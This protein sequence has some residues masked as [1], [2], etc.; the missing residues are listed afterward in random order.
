MVVTFKDYGLA[1]AEAMGA[2]VARASRPAPRVA[3][4]WLSTHQLTWFGACADHH[5]VQ[6]SWSFGELRDALL[7]EPGRRATVGTFAL[8]QAI[9]PEVKE[10]QLRG[11]CEGLIPQGTDGATRVF[12]MRVASQLAVADFLLTLP[13]LL[14]CD[15][16]LFLRPDVLDKPAPTPRWPAH[17]RDRVAA[18]LAAMDPAFASRCERLWTAEA[19]VLLDA[20]RSLSP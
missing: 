4:H 19:P 18:A 1:V 17:A 10:H 16:S 20:L 15:V 14:G 6:A 12:L 8:T 5:V 11:L 2:V 13:D 7:R 3:Q 9:F